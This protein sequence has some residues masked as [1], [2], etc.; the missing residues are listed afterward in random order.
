LGLCHQDMT[1]GYL[2][3]ADQQKL[4]AGMN[5]FK[6]LNMGVLDGRWT[7]NEI[8]YQ[9][10]TEMRT[11]G[12]SCLMID[13]LGKVKLPAGMSKTGGKL[14][15]IYNFIL[16]E[17]VD[18]AVELNIPVIVTHHLNKDN[19]R[20]GKN[21]RPSTGSLREAGDMWTHN[22]ILIYREYLQTQDPKV[23]T[24]AEFIVGK[25]RDG[26]V[27]TVELNFNGPSKNFYQIEEH[28]EPPKVMAGAEQWGN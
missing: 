19:A 14:H 7:V 17:L 6:L 11:K 20:R 16:E 15:D 1:A 27:G 22:V 25:A 23:K 18:I 5:K 26:E 12:I 9:A 3:E 8:R 10:I 28:R 24:L 21:N 2:N 13:S 4:S